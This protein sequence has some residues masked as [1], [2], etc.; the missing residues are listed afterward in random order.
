MGCAEH[1]VR[2]KGV[3]NVKNVLVGK[4]Q[5][6]KPLWKPR[7]RKKYEWYLQKLVSE[8]KN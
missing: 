3:I 8:D 4:P 2:V 1:V 6:M 7:H 5:V